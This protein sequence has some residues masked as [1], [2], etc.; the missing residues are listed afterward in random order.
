[1]SAE[2]ILTGSFGVGKS[3]IFNRFIYDEF[4]DKYYGTIGVRV[5]GREMNV[6]DSNIQLKLWDTAGEVKQDK[7]PIAY[8]KSKDVIL[9]IVDLNRPFTFKNVPHDIHYLS[10]NSPNSNLI[11]VGNKID[12][13]DE[14]R[15]KEIKSKEFPIQFDWLASAKTGE[16]INE[17]FY[18][19][20]E[21]YK[22]VH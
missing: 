11:I 1:M 9:Y 18:S 22:E 15:L 8:F 4:D 17:L 6:N 5:N 20:A 19:I 12:L 7:V 16:N 14:D 3:S 13:I 21:E 10:K 2:I